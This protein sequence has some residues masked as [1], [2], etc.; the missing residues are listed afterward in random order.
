MVS[1]SLFKKYDIRGVAMGD[2]APLTKDAAMLIGQAIGT[3]MQRIESTSKV[4][5]GRDNR[6][7]SL[8]LQDALMAGLAK[9]GCDVVDIGLV[10]TPLVYWHAIHEETKGGVMVTGSHLPAQYNGFKISVGTRNV[11]SSRLQMIAKMVE[12][13]D[14][15][16]GKGALESNQ[17]AYSQYIRDIVKRISIDKSFKVALDAGNGTGGLFSPR[18]LELWQQELVGSLYLDPDGTFPNHVPNP[19]HEENVH[20]LGELVRET[21]ADIGVAFDGDA[22]R[23]GVLDEKGNLIAADRILTLL[24]VDMLDRHPKSAVV[25]EVLCSQVLFDAVRQAGG[26]PFMAA[27]G[28]AIV[29]D[30]MREVSALIGGEMSGHMFFGEDY[31]GFD[32][33]FFA[34]GRVLQLMAN[35]GKTLSELDAQLPKLY[36]TP[37]YRPHCPDEDKDFVIEGVANQLRDKGTISD[38]DGVRLQ[39]P[40]GWGIL[41]ASNTEPVLSLRFEGK[42]EADALEIRKLFEFALAQYP[43]VEKFT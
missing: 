34:M 7:T 17:S 3:Y 30:K 35:S 29:K 19:Q 25:G 13:N 42:T 14:F 10:S 18:L 36:S 5:V 21:Q 8:M 9:S 32:D 33:G 37:E 15:Q 26:V 12:E 1:Q 4:V 41:R 11:Y 31:F 2:D 28:H 23:I 20:E 39:M 38:I 40:N 16:S 6:Q 43:K 22:D 24:A 27:S